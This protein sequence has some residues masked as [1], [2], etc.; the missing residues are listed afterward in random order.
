[1]AQDLVFPSADGT[2]SIT[3]PMQRV[4][5]AMA[6]TEEVQS[7]TAFK[8]PELLGFL[9]RELNFVGKLVL[10]VNQH[11]LL[12]A[13]LL[14]TRRAIILTDLLPAMLEAKGLNN[15]KEIRDAAIA[16]DAEYQQLED[17]HQQILAVRE[18]LKLDAEGI[19]NAFGAIKRLLDSRALTTGAGAVDLATVTGRPPP[20]TSYQTNGLR[21]AV[22]DMI[23][24]E[25]PSGAVCA[26][27]H[28]GAPGYEPKGD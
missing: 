24:Y 17:R 25:T 7:V 5:R 6:R 14:A 19:Y 12:A 13:R 20:V 2:R 22:C 27:G 28:G 1:M 9:N 8:A 18:M 26:Q 11:A 15:N 3:L 4:R 16:V 10:A 21:C 23:Q